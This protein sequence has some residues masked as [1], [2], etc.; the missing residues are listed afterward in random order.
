MQEHFARNMESKLSLFKIGMIIEMSWQFSSTTIGTNTTVSSSLS[1]NF[2]YLK[3][4]TSN[5]FY[6]HQKQLEICRKAAG[7]PRQKQDRRIFF[8]QKL[9]RVY[10]LETLWVENFDEIALSLTVK[11]IE[12]ILGF[13]LECWEQ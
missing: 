3:P 13:N 4:N 9:G 12:A 5:H 10:C 11:E 8:V 2:D 7:I 1:T 6:V